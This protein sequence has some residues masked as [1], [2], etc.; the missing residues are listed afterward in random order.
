EGWPAPGVAMKHGTDYMPRLN[1]LPG[2][3]PIQNGPQNAVPVSPCYATVGNGNGT[4]PSNTYVPV[5][6]TATSTY[7]PVPTDTVTSV[8]GGGDTSTTTYVP[9]ETSQTYGNGGNGG[10]STYVPVNTGTTNA[11]ST[12]PTGTVYGGSSTATTLATTATKKKCKPSTIKA[13]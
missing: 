4:L 10:S 8:Y 7:V 2:C 11:V 6:T 12:V 5:P 9:V 13:Y 3:N 1:A